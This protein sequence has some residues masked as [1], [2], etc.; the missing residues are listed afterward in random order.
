[1]H[2]TP[3]A[4]HSTLRL[5]NSKG[6]TFFREPGGKRELTPFILESTCNFIRAGYESS[7]NPTLKEVEAH[8]RTQLILD[9]DKK[10]Q[11][12]ANFDPN[13]VIPKKTLLKALKM[14]NASPNITGLYNSYIYI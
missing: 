4:P 9:Q 1:V 3:G 7:N 13:A 6:T 8:A 2:R 5:S 10:P 12:D 11:R 14:I